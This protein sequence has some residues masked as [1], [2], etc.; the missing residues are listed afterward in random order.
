MSK[1]DLF[2]Y[3][4]VLVVLLHDPKC[5]RGCNKTKKVLI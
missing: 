4:F 3:I 2:I 1:N 5:C